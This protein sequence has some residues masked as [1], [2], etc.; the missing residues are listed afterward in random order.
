MSKINIDESITRL[1]VVFHQFI[2]SSARYIDAKHKKD[3]T[4]C[5]FLIMILRTTIFDISVNASF[6]LSLI[7]RSVYEG[8]KDV[9][10]MY[11]KD[12]N[13]YVKAMDHIYGRTESVGKIL[14]YIEK[15]PKITFE[16]FI[17]IMYW[18]GQ[19]VCVSKNE[20]IRVTSHNRK[21]LSSECW[22]DTYSK[23]GVILLDK[24]TGVVVPPKRFAEYELVHRLK[25]GTFKINTSAV[26]EKHALN[27][28]LKYDH[29]E[30]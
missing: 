12:N 8:R 21:T 10:G 25:N 24:K 3:N 26:G 11:C 16:E 27:K 22:N 9:W 14:R 20:H 17:P 29:P 30:N 7:S 2:D 5:K 4:Y 19:R 15:H 13:D 18:A 28:L 1:K 6:N 23:N